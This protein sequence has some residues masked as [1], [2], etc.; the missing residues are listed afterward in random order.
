[1]QL[2][3]YYQVAYHVNQLLST[4]IEE[5]LQEFFTNLEPLIVHN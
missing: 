1:M 3:P 5:H 2:A 4:L